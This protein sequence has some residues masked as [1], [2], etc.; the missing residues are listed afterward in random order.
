MI[1]VFQI[2]ILIHLHLVINCPIGS[3]SSVLGKASRG[4]E[5]GE[6]DCR[7]CSGNITCYYSAPQ[8]HCNEY[9]YLKNTL[10]FRNTL[11]NNIIVTC[12]IQ[13]LQYISRVIVA[14][15]AVKEGEVVARHS[16][17]A[18]KCSLETPMSR[19]VLLTWPSYTESTRSSR[20]S[21]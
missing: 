1:V 19:R 16:K 21:S 2:P 18:P 12:I 5:E 14:L 4:R 9:L 10:K 11:E 8:V 20:S 7:T 3:Y 17:V 13:Y 6:R 15:S